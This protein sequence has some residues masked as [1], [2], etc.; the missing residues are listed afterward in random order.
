MHANINM[1]GVT[2]V[3]LFS[4]YQFAIGVVIFLFCLPLV[5]ALVPIV[6][7]YQDT[8]SEQGNYAEADGQVQ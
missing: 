3:V 8:Y 2:G 7:Q 1:S 5:P 4:K 6:P